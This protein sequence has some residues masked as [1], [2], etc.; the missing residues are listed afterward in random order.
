M[1]RLHYYNTHSLACALADSIFSRGRK[2]PAESLI[3]FFSKMIAPGVLCV[4]TGWKR[5]P[6]LVSYCMLMWS[7]DDVCNHI[8]LQSGATLALNIVAVIA[9]SS[10]L[11]VSAKEWKSMNN[12]YHKYFNYG[13]KQIIICTISQFTLVKRI[14]NIYF[15]ENVAW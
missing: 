8:F 3:N 5:R 4:L 6:A 10:C 1:H 13:K 15:G 12:C 11:Y 9:S 2:L 7:C 14:L